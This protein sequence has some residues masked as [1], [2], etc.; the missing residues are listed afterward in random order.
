MIDGIVLGRFEKGNSILHKMDARIKLFF[1]I[2]NMVVI[3]LVKSFISFGIL[4]VANVILY[5]VCAFSIKSTIKEIKMASILMLS[6]A[7]LNFLILLINGS[8]KGPYVFQFY[9]FKI[10]TEIVKLTAT[11]F[12]R[13]ILLIFEFSFLSKTTTS[14]ELTFAMKKFIEPLKIFKIKVDEIAIILSIA[15]RFVPVLLNEANQIMMAQKN[16]GF[17]LKKARIN[18]KAQF[19]IRTIKVLLVN[20]LRRSNEIAIAME[21]RCY[22]IGVK[23][24]Q[25][26]IYKMKIEDFVMAAIGIVC[27]VSVV[28]IDFLMFQKFKILL[29]NN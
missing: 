25:F 18:Q 3:L 17:N 4:L 14:T 29:I 15:M 22:R 1:A 8:F 5:A 24:S 7:I 23:R 10:P 9:W 16:R 2:F 6:T 13:L 19:F 26:N 11:L 28:L 21:S 12:F 27:L 20:S